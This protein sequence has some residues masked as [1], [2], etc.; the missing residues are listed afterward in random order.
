[1]IAASSRLRILPNEAWNIISQYAGAENIICFPSRTQS[2][3]ICCRQA[4][5]EAEE[6][7]LER[8]AAEAE[9]NKLQALYRVSAARPTLESL[10]DNLSQLFVVPTAFVDAWRES[11]RPKSTTRTPQA[12]DYEDQSNALLCKC[13]NDGNRFLRSVC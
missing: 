5:E 3:E 2:C 10:S 9:K 12:I 11:R 8:S 7:Q 1:M 13:T 6:R 4:I